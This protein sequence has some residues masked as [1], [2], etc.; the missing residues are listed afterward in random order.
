MQKNANLD[1]A[2]AF[3]L[4]P[5]ARPMNCNMCVQFLPQYAWI[6]MLLVLWRLNAAESR[7]QSP[8]FSPSTL[9]KDCVLSSSRQLYFFA[10]HCGIRFLKPLSQI[11]SLPWSPRQCSTCG[12]QQCG[13]F[14]LPGSIFDSGKHIQNDTIHTDPLSLSIL[15]NPHQSSNLSWA[16]NTTL[17]PWSVVLCR[18]PTAALGGVERMRFDF[19][20]VTV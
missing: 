17:R 20:V 4:H 19:E 8:M 5:M 18:V 14:D 15:L 1:T 11:Q 7:Y 10:E 13:S 2:R 16:A 3:Y 6:S 9:S 12:L